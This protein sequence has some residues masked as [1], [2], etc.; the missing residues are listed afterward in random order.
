MLRRQAAF[1]DSGSPLPIRMSEVQAG[2]E[3]FCFSM[4][5]ADD[6]GNIIR[7]ILHLDTVWM[8]TARTNIKKDME[9]RKKK[10]E[11]GTNANTKDGNRRS[12]R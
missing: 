7:M 3:A 10:N 8:S 6:T 1:T 5:G 11:R 9:A 12:G 4:L 2:I